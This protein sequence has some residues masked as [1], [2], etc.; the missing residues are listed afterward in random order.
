MN[1][2]EVTVRNLLHKKGLRGERLEECMEHVKSDLSLC[3]VRWGK[4]DTIGISDTLRADVE[5]VVIEWLIAQIGNSVQ[6]GE[7]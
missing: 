2:I 3:N 7:V 5:G 1:T 4:E 6:K